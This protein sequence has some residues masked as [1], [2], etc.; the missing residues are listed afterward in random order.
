MVSVREIGVNRPTYMHGFVTCSQRW[1][2][3]KKDKRLQDS[4]DGGAERSARVP[5]NLSNLQVG[6]WN[7]DSAELPK[8]ETVSRY[9][10][11]PSREQRENNG[12]VAQ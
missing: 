4:G 7:L 12:S 2:F 9:D 11:K 10:P 8:T 3:K 6:R 1:S 5:F